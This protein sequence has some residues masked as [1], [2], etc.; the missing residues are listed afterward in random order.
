[1]IRLKKKGREDRITES[2]TQKKWGTLPITHKDRIMECSRIRGAARR[3]MVK[4]L[5]RRQ[6][7][8][9]AM[10]QETKLKE[11][12]HSIVRELWGRKHVKWVARDA[13]GTSGDLL[14]MWDSQFVD[15]SNS[16]VDEISQF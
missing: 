8:H 10:L 2:V 9:I 14:V 16:W 11:V 15:V 4:E 3:Q 5:V 12:L 13:I 7:V 1:M 6:K